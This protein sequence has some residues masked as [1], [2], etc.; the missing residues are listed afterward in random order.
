MQTLELNGL[1]ELNHEE[2]KNIDGGDAIQMAWD[3]TPANG[4]GSYDNQGGGNWTGGAFSHSHAWAVLFN[5]DTGV[6]RDY[7]IW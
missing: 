1:Q 6:T 3:A 7:Q 2:L 5:T 4:S